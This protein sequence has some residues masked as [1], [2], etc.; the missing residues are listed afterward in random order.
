MPSLP[1]RYLPI[2][3]TVFLCSCGFS[4]HG[5]L[6]P[7]GP[8]AEAQKNHLL[9]ITGW[10]LVVIVPLFIALPIVLWKYRFGNR[11]SLY[12]PN[13]SF[14]WLLEGLIWGLPLIIVSILSWNVWW[15]SKE[16]DPYAPISSDQPALHIQVIGLDWKWLFIY[17]DQ[18]IA[19]VNQLVIPVNR[20]IEFE[21]TS[22][23]VMQSFMIPRLGSQI[24]AMPGMVS[25]LHLLASETG[26]FRG[27]NTQYNGRSF[28]KQKFITRALSGD[29]FRAWINRQKTNP[30]LDMPT[31]NR[32]ARR[33]VPKRPEFFGDVAPDLFERIVTRVKNTPADELP[34]AAP[35]RSQGG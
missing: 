10:T 17:P 1:A 3:A 21:L 11:K 20:P 13:W 35:K 16:L 4:E 28:A 26:N 14:S 7:S 31:Y 15:V 23:T 19:S 32:V 9:S 34:G 12:R 18:R 25:Q 30:P 2:T 8:I 33:S 29:E 6:A 22:E 5:F 27:Q 24:Y